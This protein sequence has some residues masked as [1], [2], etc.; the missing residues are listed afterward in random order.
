MKK[1]IHFIFFACLLIFFNSNLNADESLCLDEEGFI[2]P[3]FGNDICSNNSKEAVLAN[4]SDIPHDKFE[5]KRIPF[6]DS[7]IPYNW[8]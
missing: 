7:S 4:C 3:I 5:I 2:Y 1:K 8:R 6:D